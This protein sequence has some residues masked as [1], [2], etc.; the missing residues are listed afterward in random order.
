MISD[1][2][3][4]LGGSHARSDLL[5][6]W[7]RAIARADGALV[8]V[9]GGG[10]FADA[11][12][13]VQ[14][15]LGFDDRAAHDMALLAMAQYG[16]ALAALEPRLTLADTPEALLAALAR[17]NL[18]VWSP[19]PM[20]RDAAEIEASWNVTSDSLALWL[21]RALGCARLLLIKHRAPG[22]D[23]Q[24]GALVRSGLL[25]SAFPDYLRGFDGTVWIA[26]PNDLPAAPIDPKAPPGTR[27]AP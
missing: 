20:A 12:R 3:V 6:P 19:W 1:L 24:C 8:L 10:P 13:D 25:D 18:P 9:P 7:L 23:P 14:P 4:K 21:A 11:V 2:V 22:P 15:A 26:G 5:R 27:L 17:G 16:R